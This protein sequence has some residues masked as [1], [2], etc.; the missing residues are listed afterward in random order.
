MPK[1]LRGRIALPGLDLG[2]AG[3]AGTGWAL[4]AQVLDPAA[5]AGEGRLLL[6]RVARKHQ[7]AR[8]HGREP[9]QPLG[10]G[11]HEFRLGWVGELPSRLRGPRPLRILELCAAR[12]AGSKRPLLAQNHRRAPV[13]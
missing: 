12:S 11:L 10:I 4:L 9:D 6:L 13:G 2:Q 1:Y 7:R 8:P 5:A 3:T